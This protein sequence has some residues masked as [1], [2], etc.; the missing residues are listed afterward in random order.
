MCRKAN[1]VRAQSY[2]TLSDLMDCAHKTPLS[3]GFP[4]LEYWSGLPF[5]SPGDLPKPGIEPMSPALRADSLLSEPPG[6]P[7][8]RSTDEKVL[9]IPHS[10]PSHSSYNRHLISGPK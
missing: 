10:F 4:R 1:C 6:K 7:Q 2:L 3:M 9:G 8:K 5:S